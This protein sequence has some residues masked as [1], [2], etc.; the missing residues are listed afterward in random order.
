[1]NIVNEVQGQIQL[2][3]EDTP[4][5]EVTCLNKDTGCHLRSPRLSLLS[6][7]HPCRWVLSWVPS[8]I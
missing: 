1:M 2:S 6:S 8:H 5:A 7:S 3:L 4:R